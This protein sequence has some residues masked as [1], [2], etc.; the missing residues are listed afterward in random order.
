MTSILAN[1]RKRFN[2]HKVCF[3][4]LHVVACFFW[5][6]MAP[7]YM[8]KDI[9][10]PMSIGPETRTIEST[11]HVSERILGIDCNCPICMAKNRYHSGKGFFGTFCIKIKY[12]FKTAVF[13]MTCVR[14]LRST[15]IF[16]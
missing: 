5:K 6:P 12:S 4:P 16:F 15:T 9:L 8:L 3:G 11:A 14:E 7:Q 2:N 13:Y 10:V 1:E